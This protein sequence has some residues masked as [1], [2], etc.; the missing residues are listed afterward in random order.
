MPCQVEEGGTLRGEQGQ[1]IMCSCTS[2]ACCTLTCS[3]IHELHL[4]LARACAGGQGV[5]YPH[6]Q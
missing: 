3:H 5:L 1:Y 2:R 4:L 6:L